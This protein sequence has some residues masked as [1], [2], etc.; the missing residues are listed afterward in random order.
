MADLGAESFFLAPRARVEINNLV[1]WMIGLLGAGQ[2][3]GR[4]ELKV[5]AN[6]ENLRLRVEVVN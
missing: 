6:W 3:L 5:V 4:E 2:E 1:G